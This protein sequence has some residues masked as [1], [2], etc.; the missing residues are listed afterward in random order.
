M[1]AQAGVESGRTDNDNGVTACDTAKNSAR[2]ALAPPVHEGRR[3]FRKLSLEWREG[4]G[5][6]FLWSPPCA[7][8][9]RGLFVMTP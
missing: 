3:G 2:S 8:V 6:Y 5:P 1:V 9:L 7:S 4:E